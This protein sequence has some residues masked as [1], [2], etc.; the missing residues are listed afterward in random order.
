MSDAIE[1]LGTHYWKVSTDTWVEATGEVA[2]GSLSGTGNPI[3]V[4]AGS[5]LTV[6]GLA[7]GMTPY[8]LWFSEPPDTGEPEPGEESSPVGCACTSAPNKK[9]LGWGAFL[10]ASL[11]HRRKHPL[12]GA[13]VKN[14]VP[15]DLS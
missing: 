4:Q 1:F 10:I 14:S 3:Q 15:P 13:Q 8:S 5:W 9:M 6:S 2:L 11:I 12:L 7:D